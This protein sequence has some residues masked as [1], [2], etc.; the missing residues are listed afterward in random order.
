MPSRYLVSAHHAVQCGVSVLHLEI[1]SK[2]SKV[3]SLR[4]R[5]TSL[6]GSN[7]IRG[8]VGGENSNGVNVPPCA[9]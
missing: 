1:S 2:E 8:G 4:K 9:P 7:D 5:G 6:S 3:K